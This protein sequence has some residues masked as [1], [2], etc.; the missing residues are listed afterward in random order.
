MVKILTNNLSNYEKNELYR[1]YI[2]KVI[3][4]P[5]FPKYKGTNGQILGKIEG[6]PIL[7]TKDS[8]VLIEEYESNVKLKT[9]D[10]LIGK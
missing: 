10:R 4:N 3:Y 9:G 5:D 6:M 1:D 2:N 8:Y 7:K